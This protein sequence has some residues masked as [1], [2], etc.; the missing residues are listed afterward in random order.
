MGWTEACGQRSRQDAGGCVW[1]LGPLM[2]TDLWAA[3]RHLGRTHPRL[4]VAMNTEEKSK[5]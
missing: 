2:S 3:I 1:G 5:L 4:D